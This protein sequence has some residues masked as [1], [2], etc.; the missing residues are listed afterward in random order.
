M[1]HLGRVSPAAGKRGSA[2]VQIESTIVSAADDPLQPLRR[3]AR[4]RSRSGRGGTGRARAARSRCAARCPRAGRADA[5]GTRRPIET[6]SPRRQ[7]REREPAGGRDRGAGATARTAT[8]ARATIDDR[9]DD[10]ERSDERRARVPP[11]G[12]ER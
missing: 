8:S 10:A 2:N 12:L 4:R 6:I 3:A 9:V 11:G 5:S 7:E 1:N